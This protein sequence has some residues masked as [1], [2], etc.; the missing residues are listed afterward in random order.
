MTKD[1]MKDLFERFK[2]GNFTVTFWDGEVCRYGQ[3]PPV[4]NIIFKKPLSSTFNPD[5]PLLSLGE[6]YMEGDWDFTG[7]FEEI[8]R[9]IEENKD[10]LKPAGITGKLTGLF[11]TVAGKRK[12]KQNI[13]HHYDLG[14]DFFSLWLD[15]TLSYSCAY[16][17]QPD[18]SLYQAQINKIDHILKKLQLK[19]GERLL[20]IGCGWGWLVIRAAQQYGVRALGITLSDQQYEGARQRVRELGLDGQVDIQLANYLDLSERDYQFDKIVSVGMFEHVGKDNIPSYMDRV[21]NLLVP[22]GLSLLHTIT[23]MTEEPVNAWIEKYIFPGGYIPSLR[24]IIGLLPEYRF[25]LLHAESLRLHY[26]KTL[27]HWYANFT[28]CCEKVREKFDERFVRMWGLYLRGCAASFR[29][30]GLD[31]YQLL[32]SKGLNNSLP[33]EYSFIYRD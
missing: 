23:G 15:E 33:M 3:S 26:A 14:N 4:V 29:V 30:S 9:I 2:V 27:D 10:Q 1:M 19:P 21:N 25:H 11:Q 12:Q 8:I 18:D 31:I 28:R 7:E 20:D 22:G 6:A 32:F 16:F 5:N 17:K 24:E 13:E